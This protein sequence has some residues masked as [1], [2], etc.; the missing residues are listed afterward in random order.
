LRR[1]IL[2]TRFAWIIAGLVGVLAFSHF[3]HNSAHA[4]TIATSAQSD[5]MRE[6]ARDAGREQAE[7]IRAAA[8]DR[9]DAARDAAD[10]AREQA[11]AFRDQA[12]DN[13]DAMREAA[14]AERDALREEARALRDA[15]RSEHIHI[16]IPSTI[17]IDTNS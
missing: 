16:T 9:V 7:A 12:R 14:R 4:Q 3:G 15:R 1:P 6:V 10:A 8:Q 5:A 11:E 2:T 13:A 17:D